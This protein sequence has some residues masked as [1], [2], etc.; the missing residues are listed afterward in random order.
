MGIQLQCLLNNFCCCTI[1]L[2]LMVTIDIPQTKIAVCKLGQS[3]TLRELSRQYVNL[4]TDN[5]VPMGAMG[6][7]LSSG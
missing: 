5:S 7:D 6:R 4:S 2:L 3:I 1:N